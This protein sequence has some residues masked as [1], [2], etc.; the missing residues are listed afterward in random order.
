[1]LGSGRSLTPAAPTS[2]PQKHSRIHSPSPSS[3][4]LN[5]QG[6]ASQFSADTRDIVSRISLE[7]GNSSISRAA[8]AAGS[9]RLACPICNEEMVSLHPLYFCAGQQSLYPF[10]FILVFFFG[11]AHYDAN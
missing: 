3:V 2:S 9:P 10:Y 1:M 11:N 6:T 8:A 4:S 7:N 5:S